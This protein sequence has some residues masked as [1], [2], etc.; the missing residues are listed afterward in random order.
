MKVYEVS[1]IL[2]IDNP[3]IIKE[4]INKFAKNIFLGNAII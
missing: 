2:E 1:E 4:N 3:D